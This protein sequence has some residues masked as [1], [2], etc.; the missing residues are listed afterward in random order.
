MKE[1]DFDIS[2]RNLLQDAEMPVSGKVWKGVEAAIAPR[3]FV[4]PFW[5]YALS[6]VAA[7]AAIALGVFLFRPAT[8]GNIYQGAIALEPGQVKTE[9]MDAKVVAPIRRQIA[10]SAVSEASTAYLE[11]AEEEMA[12]N[13]QP[14][15]VPVMEEVVVRELPSAVR[16]NAPKRYNVNDDNAALN[17]LAFAEERKHEPTISFN[18]SG[19]FQNNNRNTF[20]RSRNYTPPYPEE[21]TGEGI[22]NA[23]PEISFGMPV[24]FGIGAT[25]RFADRWSVGLGIRY[26][27]LSRTFQGDFYDEDKFPRA[28]NK[29]IDN[30]QHW[31][32][33]PVNLFF[34]LISSRYWHFH[35]FVGGTAEFLLDNDFLVH[36]SPNDFH[37]HQNS[38]YPPQFSFG[39][40]LGIEFRFMNNMGVYFD[41]SLRY[42][43]G[44]A[45]QPRSIRTVQPLRL[46]VEAGMR[47]YF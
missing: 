8:S 28:I 45:N 34:D 43:L 19:D 20:S 41:P 16:S 5:A 35:T 44:T 13:L 40:G 32:G 33:L 37:Y 46:D 7:A 9:M 30:F 38:G 27:W 18:A 11:S 4:V 36:A 39:A 21:I 14:E 2:V 31:L 26:T 6:G 15:E 10:S 25:Y 29:D 17:R 23:Y 1:T 12:Q 22:Y 47:F 3:R 24:A 42:Y